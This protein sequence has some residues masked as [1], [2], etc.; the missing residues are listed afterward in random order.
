[1]MM[2]MTMTMMMMMMTMT[3]RNWGCQQ[4]S[5]FLVS[6]RLFENPDPVW[7][8]MFDGIFDGILMRA[9]GHLVTTLIL[10]GN[11]MVYFQYDWMDF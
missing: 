4:I 6:F 3:M 7:K 1:M 2:M 5:P 10:N 9:S 11:L 8:Q